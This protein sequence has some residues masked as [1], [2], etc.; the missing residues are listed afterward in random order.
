MNKV[1]MDDI[2]EKYQELNPEGHWFDEDT[3][4]FFDCKLPENGY[5]DGDDIYFITGERD[6]YM[7]RQPRHL[8]TVRRMDSEGDID[9]VSKFQE[10]KSLMKAERALNNI[11]NGD[12]T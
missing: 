7:G 5:I 4:R 8:Y 1:S 2:K 12:V 6:T 9:S 10:F 11:L 3:M